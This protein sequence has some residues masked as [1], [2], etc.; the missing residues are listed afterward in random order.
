MYLLNR[1]RPVNA[2]T[3]TITKSSAQDIGFKFEIGIEI[4][5]TRCLQFL[6]FFFIAYLLTEV[7]VIYVYVK[8]GDK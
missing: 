8:V 5:T 6:P 1:K 4:I 7:L 2:S 3:S